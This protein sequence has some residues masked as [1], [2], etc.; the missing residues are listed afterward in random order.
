MLAGTELYWLVLSYVGWYRVMLAGTELCW[1]VLSY[2]D[3]YRVILAITEL[4]WLAV[5]SEHATGLPMCAICYTAKLYLPHSVINIS[6]NT[7]VVTVN[8]LF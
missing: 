4:H 3:Y 8:H 2:I 6:R 1:P 7:F 5:C